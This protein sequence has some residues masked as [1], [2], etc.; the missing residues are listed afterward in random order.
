MVRLE[1]VLLN[2][3]ADL[4]STD[5]TRNTRYAAGSWYDRQTPADDVG[6]ALPRKCDR[7]TTCSGATAATRTANAAAP[8]VATCAC[9]CAEQDETGAADAAL[10]GIAA[11]SAHT[12]SSTCT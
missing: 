4:S 9:S 7:S 12:G 3:A 11:S 10:T 1:D 8:T 2:R 5:C 6:T